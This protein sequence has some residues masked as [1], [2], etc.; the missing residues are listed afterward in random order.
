MKRLPQTIYPTKFPLPFT[1][2]YLHALLYLPD[3]FTS[4]AIYRQQY[5]RLAINNFWRSGEN[6]LRAIFLENHPY[7]S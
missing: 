4:D 7:V 1:V 3:F 5:I 6:M 2:Q